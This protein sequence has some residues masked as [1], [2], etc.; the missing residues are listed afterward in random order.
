MD[1]NKSSIIMSNVNNNDYPDF[2]DAYIEYAENNDGI[3]LS[4][5]ELE[6]LNENTLLLNEQAFE[7]FINARQ[8]R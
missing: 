3:E 6:K 7:H 8:K 5:K 2:V 1:I 4:D